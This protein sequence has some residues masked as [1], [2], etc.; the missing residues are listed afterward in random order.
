MT[1]IKLKNRVKKIEYIDIIFEMYN[2][3]LILSYL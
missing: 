1:L 2:N 3:N